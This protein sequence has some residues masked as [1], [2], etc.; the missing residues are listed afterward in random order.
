MYHNQEIKNQLQKRII[1]CIN[2]GS[3]ELGVP[4]LILHIDYTFSKRNSISSAKTGF[5]ESYLFFALKDIEE[6][7]IKGKDSE[8]TE[9][10]KI[11]NEWRE[12][13][14]FIG[15]W[16]SHLNALVSH[17]MAHVFESLAQKEPHSNTKI[18]SYYGLQISKGKYKHHNK[19]WRL[20]YRDLRNKSI[21]STDKMFLI[22][23]HNGFD[24]YYYT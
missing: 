19:L 2:F 14:S 4:L 21:E 11:S 17:E 8:F 6:A 24:C 22:N 5:L 12:T 9:F 23:R 7:K 13:G 3:K 20:I 10:H 15:D 1:E 18:N 16:Q